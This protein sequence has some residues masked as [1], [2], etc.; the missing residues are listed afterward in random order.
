[1]RK[2]F[3]T[4]H[5]ALERNIQI[6]SKTIDK[7]VISTS[8]LNSQFFFED[9][10][11]SMTEDE[12]DLIGSSREV[13]S[14]L[15]TTPEAPST[16]DNEAQDNENN[17]RILQ[18]ISSNAGTGENQPLPV[19]AREC[20]TQI[21]SMIERMK[22]LRA[23]IEYLKESYERQIIQSKSRIAFLK[24]LDHPE[25]D[26]AESDAFKDWV[27][28]RLEMSISDFFYR[29]GMINTARLHYESLGI[30]NLVDS[31]KLEECVFLESRLRRDHSYTACLSWCKEN[32][33]FLAKMDST[34]E[35]EL[36]LQKYIELARLGQKQDA[37]TCFRTE[38]Y[39]KASENATTLKRASSLLFVDPEGLIGQNIEFYSRNR[40]ETLGNL[41]VT[42]FRKLHMLPP[43]STFLQHLGLG[44]SALK[45]RSCNLHIE[46]GGNSDEEN[47]WANLICHESQ[48]SQEATPEAPDENS[49]ELINERRKKWFELNKCPVCCEE[50]CKI[51]AHLPYAKHLKS[52]LDSDPVVLPNGRVYSLKSIKE[53]SQKEASEGKILDPCTHEEFSEDMYSVVYPS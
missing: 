2:T 18:P 11:K 52:H 50:L 46:N 12:N 30:E 22:G 23:T 28:D 40:W 48:G 51:A 43:E 35:F 9:S 20:L 49:K 39:P 31:E 42:T 16:V 19:E 53:Y 47:E 27:M 4:A 25:M 3:K 17:T 29:K 37:L 13:G 14:T 45:T 36:L 26:N 8:K 15:D 24:R 5:R 38:L 33:V 44:I 1:M 41:F 34:L 10:D 21:D 32:K 6:S 7:L